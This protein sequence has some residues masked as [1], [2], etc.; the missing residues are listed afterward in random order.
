M[1][2]SG[3]GKT[4]LMNVLSM[5]CNLSKCKLEGKVYLNDTAEMDQNLF[6]N[7]GAYVM[8]DD[9]IFEYFTVRE[10]LN[11]AARLKLDLPRE[12]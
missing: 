3:A 10:A 11:F 12:E 2:A 9:N 7:Y 6:G 8:Q 5:R 4:S 1:G